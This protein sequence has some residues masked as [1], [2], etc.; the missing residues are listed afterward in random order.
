MNTLRDQVTMQ[1]V[2]VIMLGGAS[3]QPLQ[4]EVRKQGTSPPGLLMPLTLH[5]PLV[6]FGFRGVDFCFCSVR[7]FPVYV[8]FFAP[9]L[10]SVL[11]RSVS[12]P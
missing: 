11:L 8:T 7:V 5:D 12:S 3:W 10:C 2:L 9:L 6:R 1:P 4:S